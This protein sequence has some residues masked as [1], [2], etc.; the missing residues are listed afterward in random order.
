MKVIDGEFRFFSGS[1]ETSIWG[2]Q[3]QPGKSP[4]RTVP[5]KVKKKL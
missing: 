4:D 1:L 5:K 2:A 3:K